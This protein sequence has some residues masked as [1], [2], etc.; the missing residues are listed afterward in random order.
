MGRSKYF[1]RPWNLRRSAQRLIF[2][3]HKMLK[4]PRCFIKADRRNTEYSEMLI[5]KTSDTLSI[6]EQKKD[7]L[8][9]ST[10]KKAQNA[11]QNEW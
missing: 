11:S 4:L 2:H 6:S 10:P 9:T 1:R 7:H 8:Y 5:D 3:L